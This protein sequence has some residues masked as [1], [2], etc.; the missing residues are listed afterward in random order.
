MIRYGK[1]ADLPGL[2][3][4]W[5]ECFADEDAYI[6]AFF[7]ALYQDEHVL[8]EEEQ[9]MLMGA[10]FFLP[11]KI[12]MEGAGAGEQSWQNIRYVYALAVYPQYRGRGIAAALMHRAHELYKAPLIAEP[13]EEGL[14]GGFYEPLGFS[15][16]FYLKKTRLQVRA[17]KMNAQKQA[18]EYDIQAAELFPVQEREDFYFQPVQAEQYCRIRDARFRRQGYISWPARHVAFAIEQH[19]SSGGGAY[20]LHIGGREEILLYYQ[21]GQDI[22]VTETTLARQELEAYV[23]PRISGRCSRMV[24]TGAA[25]ADDVPGNQIAGMDVMEAKDC[26]TGMSYGLSQV[27]GYLNLTL[28]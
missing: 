16:N 9:G 6:D 22:F 8:L 7:H 13:A 5:K 10:S 23:L 17:A 15:G 12:D 24:L 19:T 18:Q 25:F 27:Q 14:V 28:D 26:L 3:A 21:E 1:P 11:G 4:L 20:V 2:K